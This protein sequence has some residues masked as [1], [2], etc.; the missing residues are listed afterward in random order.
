MFQ[1]VNFITFYI[2]A[3]VGI[4]IE[5]LEN[6]HGVTTKIKNFN[7]PSNFVE[8]CNLIGAAVL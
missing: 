2:C 6:M 7:K 1:C 3:V 4:I 8:I 5:W